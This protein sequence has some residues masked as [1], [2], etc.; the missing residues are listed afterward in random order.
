MSFAS[1]VVDFRCFVKLT[2]KV[3]IWYRNFG[4]RV[5]NCKKLTKKK[6]M[7]NKE[8]LENTNDKNPIDIQD[9]EATCNK[10]LCRARQI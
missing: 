2:P 10:I 9:L 3:A 5:S 7:V 8:Q 1:N 6:K 4:R